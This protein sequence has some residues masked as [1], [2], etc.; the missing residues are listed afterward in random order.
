MLRNGGIGI[1]LTRRHSQL[2]AASTK[3]FD[4]FGR[5]EIWEW[6][7]HFFL[8]PER[9]HNKARQNERT[10]GQRQSLRTVSSLAGKKAGAEIKNRLLVP[11]CCHRSQITID[12]EY[13][14]VC[15]IH[16]RSITT[17]IEWS[18]MSFQFDF[19]TFDM[20]KKIIFIVFLFSFL[21]VLPSPYWSPLETNCASTHAYTNC[22]YTLRVTGMARSASWRVRG[23]KPH[24]QITSLHVLKRAFSWQAFLSLLKLV[25][26]SLTLC[27]KLWV[28]L[29]S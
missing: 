19:A 16:S 10:S 24:V 22:T 7:V 5:R 20:S 27:L 11:L 9:L 28:I 2:L 6:T 21:L 12:D 8:F 17:F 4:D 15:T 29:V 26:A 18:G 14:W 25:G 23:S 3:A 1:I 13:R